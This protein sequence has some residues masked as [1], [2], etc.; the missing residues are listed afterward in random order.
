MHENYDKGETNIEYSMLFFVFRGFQSGFRGLRVLRGV[1][2]IGVFRVLSFGF[3]GAYGSFCFIWYT[4]MV[5]WSV[6]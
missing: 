5:A 2:C 6:S 4:L 1:G 3:G